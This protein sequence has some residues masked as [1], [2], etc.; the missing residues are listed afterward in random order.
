M[1]QYCWKKECTNSQIST[2]PKLE[3]LLMLLVL[4]SIFSSILVLNNFSWLNFAT[5]CDKAN[6]PHHDIVNLLKECE[7][8]NIN[9][10]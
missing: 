5:F 3:R 10:K 6:M 8:N 1:L 9:F 7:E 2:M 4:I